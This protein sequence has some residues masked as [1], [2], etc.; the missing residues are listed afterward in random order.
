MKD[1]LRELNSISQALRKQ[2][3][4]EYQRI[5]EPVI[6]DAQSRI[7]TDAPLSGMNR[8]WKRGSYVILPGKAGGG[9]NAALAQK[10]VKAKINTKRIKDFGGQRVNV[11]TFRLVWQGAANSIY[12]MAGRK[13]S[14]PM[15]KNLEAR[16]GKASR[17]VWPAY[18]QHKTDVEGQMVSIIEFVGK[19]VTRNLQAIKPKP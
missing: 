9:W 3:T 6:T 14:N 4:K 5:M 8:Q 18:E 2:V 7:P 11:G 16:F 17:V 10:M 13:T 1:A 15:A 19:T 12:D